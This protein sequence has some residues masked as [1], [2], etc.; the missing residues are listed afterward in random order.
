MDGYSFGS[1]ETMQPASWWKRK[2]D[3]KR[4]IIWMAFIAG[5]TFAAIVMLDFF[6]VHWASVPGIA[7][8]TASG[9]G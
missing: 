8:L 1:R 4:G 9:Q 2:V 5:M 3:V 6:G 7:V